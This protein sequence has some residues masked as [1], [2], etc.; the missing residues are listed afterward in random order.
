[1]DFEKQ[2][3]TFLIKSLRLNREKVQKRHNKKVELFKMFIQ[4]HF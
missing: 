4:N 2:I 3:M 1:M